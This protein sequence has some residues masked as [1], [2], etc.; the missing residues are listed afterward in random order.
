[1][2]NNS[3]LK[4]FFWIFW[5]VLSFESILKVEKIELKSWNF[6]HVILRPF[7]NYNDLTIYTFPKKKVKFDCSNDY[8]P[9]RVSTHVNRIAYSVCR[10]YTLLCIE[11][12]QKYRVFRINFPSLIPVI[13][14]LM[15]LT[16]IMVCI[17]NKSKGL[18]YA[19]FQVS[20]SSQLTALFENSQKKN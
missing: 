11:L 14:Q 16:C 9:R 1:M 18:R 13:S 15:T 6:Y 8:S 2:R 17:L 19:I 4:K 20:F 3:S 7:S 12:V 5:K 10:K